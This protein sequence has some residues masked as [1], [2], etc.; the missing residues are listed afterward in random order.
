[1]EPANIR[2]LYVVIGVL[3]MA[4]SFVWQRTLKQGAAGVSPASANVSSRTSAVGTLEK[5]CLP[6]TAAYASISPCAP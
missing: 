1:M 5:S 6:F 3:L 4:G 2:L